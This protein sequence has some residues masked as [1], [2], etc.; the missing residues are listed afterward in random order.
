MSINLVLDLV[1]GIAHE[2]TR[3]GIRGAHLRLGPLEGRKESCVDECWFGIL[4]F[5]GDVSRQPEVGVLVDRAGN[6]AGDVARFAK[7]LGERVGERGC[8][9]DGTKVD[10]ADVVSDETIRFSL[11]RYARGPNSRVGETERS[12]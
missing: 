5:L 7:D 9:L 10:L 4:E 1:R 3:V 2:Y 8:S 6:K 12:L 11:Q